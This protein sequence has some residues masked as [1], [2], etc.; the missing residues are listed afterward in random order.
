MYN[1][2]VSRGI[3]DKF[4]EWSLR[5]VIISQVLWTRKIQLLK[6]PQVKFIVNS[7]RNHAITG[8][9]IPFA[10]QPKSIPLEQIY[11]KKSQGIT[12][13]PLHCLPFSTSKNK[14]LKRISKSVTSVVLTLKFLWTLMFVLPQK[15]IKTNNLTAL[16]SINQV[17]EIS[18]P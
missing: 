7:T 6:L 15:R 8:Q 18:A 16:R 17:T 10:I 3:N 14:G 9:L 12:A 13:S 5:G 11:Y 2:M 1:R 4:D